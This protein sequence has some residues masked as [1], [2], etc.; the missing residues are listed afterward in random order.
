M[1]T[2]SESLVK[3]RI[4]PPMNFSSWRTERLILDPIDRRLL[5]KINAWDE[6]VSILTSADVVAL[7][8]FCLVGLLT[9][10]V[11]LLAFPGFAEIV[12]M[13]QRI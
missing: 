3:D 9:S 12:E 5:K 10:L 13:L 6:I 1:K 7:S 4:I 8:A 2:L 11:V